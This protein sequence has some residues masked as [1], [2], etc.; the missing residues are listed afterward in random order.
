MQLLRSI[1][2]VGI[3][4]T[5]NALAADNPDYSVSIVAAT[6]G[7]GISLYATS[8]IGINLIET[9]VLD[10]SNGG[11]GLLQPVA[12]A[13]NPAHDFVYVVYQ[14]S[15]FQPR[16][17]G[18]SISRLGLTHQWEKELNTGDFDLSGSTITAGPNYLIEYTYPAGPD[19]LFLYVLDQDTGKDLMHDVDPGANGV[20]LITGRVDPTRVYY[21]SCRSTSV[22]P[23]ATSVTVFAFKPGTEVQTGSATPVATSNDPNYVQS[24]CD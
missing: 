12:F 20:W 21:Y 11:G 8:K 22:S 13:M 15:G 2:V 23:P 19:Q 24:V 7:T 6:G 14:G 17:V 3:L 9:L 18:Y 10:Q 16:V 5:G 1:A 4:M